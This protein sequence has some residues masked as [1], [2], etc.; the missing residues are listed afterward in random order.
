MQTNSYSDCS[1][2]GFNESVSGTATPG[3]CHASCGQLWVFIA[4][5]TGIIVFY[6]LSG[7]PAFNIMLRWVVF[8]R[9]PLA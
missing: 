9:Q 6:F 4:F 3:L 8:D 2:T 1:C 5:L 7:V